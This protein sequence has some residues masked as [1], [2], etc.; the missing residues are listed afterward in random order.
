MSLVSKS[1]FT[2]SDLSLLCD[3]LKDFIF[4]AIMTLLRTVP[5]HLDCILSLAKYGYHMGKELIGLKKWRMI[6]NQC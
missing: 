2:C 1:R 5:I 3:S 6:T 4:L